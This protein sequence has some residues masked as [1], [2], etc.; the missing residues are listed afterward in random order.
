MRQ[1][2]STLQEVQIKMHCAAVIAHPSAYGSVDACAWDLMLRTSQ[3]IWG[4]LRDPAGLSFL[5]IKRGGA[6]GSTL[7]LAGLWPAWRSLWQMRG[8]REGT[9]KHGSSTVTAAIWLLLLPL[10]VLTVLKTGFLPQVARC[11]SRF[12]CFILGRRSIPWIGR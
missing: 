6:R 12:T 9:T 5:P 10:L 3:H 4:E 7:S 2:S 8:K 1:C 11:K